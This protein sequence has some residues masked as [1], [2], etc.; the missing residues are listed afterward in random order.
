MN[1]K[2]TIMGLFYHQVKHNPKA[3]AFIHGN[4]NITFGQLHLQS[5]VLAERLRKAGIKRQQMI[6]V[7]MQ[8]SIELMVSILAI[9]KAGA[10]YVPMDPG[11]P[12]QRLS[13]ML[14][15]LKATAV[16]LKMADDH[17]FLHQKE[18]TLIMVDAT[19]NVMESSVANNGSNI[20]INAADTAYIIYTS[21]S[22]GMPKGVMVTHGAL[23]NYL[24]NEQ[25]AYVNASK[26]PAGS[27]IHLSA[28]FDA[29]LTALFMPMIAGKFSVITTQQKAGGFT[30]EN[31]WKYAPYD[32]LKITPAHLDFLA[33]TFKTN[34]Q[35]LT[36][37]I[38]IGGE[39]LY[40]SQLDIF[41]G[42][43][44]PLEIVNEYGPTEST[45]GCAVFN[46]SINELS[47]F[48]SE[49]PIGKP[50]NHTAIYL[51]E[52][53]DGTLTPS[54]KGEMYIGGKS[55]ALGYLNNEHMTASKFVKNPLPESPYVRIY[56]TGDLARWLPNGNLAYIGRID[57]QVKISGHRVELG[58]IESTINQLEEVATSCVLFK[59]IKDANIGR[60]IAY[61][62]P[63]QQAPVVE[64]PGLAVKPVAEKIYFNVANGDI[65]EQKT[66]VD[67]D[68][69]IQQP[70][71]GN[72]TNQTTFYK[73]LANNNNV[74]EFEQHIKIVLAKQLPVYM[75][76]DHIVVKTQLPLT[77]NGKIDRIF[78]S[79]LNIESA[80]T[81]Q[82]FIKPANDAEHKLAK[83][84]EGLF[85]VNNI[86]AADN[87]FSIGG[88]SIQAARMFTLIN[89][90]FSVT[91]PL[92][93]LIKAPTIQ[94]LAVIIKRGDLF[95]GFTPIF[96]FNQQGGTTPLFL[97][98][99]GAGDILFYKDLANHLGSNQQVYGV[100]ARGL[101]GKQLPLTSIK[102]MGHYYASEILKVQPVG[103]F[104][105]A[106]YCLGAIISFEIASILTHMGHTVEFLA[107][108]HGVSP[109]YLHQPVRQIIVEQPVPGGNSLKGKM[110]Y[111]YQR[112]ASLNLVQMVAYPFQRVKRKLALGYLDTAFKARLKLYGFYLARNKAL[113]PVL[114]RKYYFD[115][116]TEMAAN[117]QPAQYQGSLTV[118]R[119]PHL[120]PE[121]TLGWKNYVAGTITTIDIP[122]YHE[123]RRVI[124]YEPHVTLLAKKMSEAL[125]SIPITTMFEV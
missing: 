56:K 59:K 39:A 97:L 57:D 54:D 65:N 102:A 25:T 91:L 75:V 82:K 108:I 79:T 77:S 73:N 38:V 78:L 70:A 90:Q 51:F 112:L 87:F 26:N 76:P 21:G 96:A 47:A 101:D 18:I 83:I 45:V 7:F 125:A 114:A 60:L 106:G 8:N 64:Q 123:N 58:E 35:W 86:S 71:T 6:P 9:F 118:F 55:L 72:T 40:P 81:G 10:V 43:N 16:L 113:P 67:T 1:E 120:Y 27:F 95:N 92:T 11:H 62:V 15:D 80:I 22:T 33:S 74:I 4:N 111:H 31:L 104:R 29:S 100:I 122:G 30:D 52:E 32:F 117:Y 93:T 20:I 14:T 124:L 116:N 94:Q 17:F 110:G 66:Q 53:K 36:Q 28:T 109:T 63:K 44:L 3:I 121:K 41:T 42:Q 37:K 105:I 89:K 119:A 85:M 68:N 103:P 5:D 107:S 34:G 61:V 12:A 23:V 48:T 84:W 98:H 69:T 46:F 2:Q 99:A 49:I 19:K 115:T 13:F 24:V 50:I 88:T